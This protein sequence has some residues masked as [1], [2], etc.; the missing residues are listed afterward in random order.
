VCGKTLTTNESKVVGIGPECRKGLSKEFLDN[1]FA[2]KVGKV[3]YEHL[4]V[5]GGEG[6]TT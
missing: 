5:E 2:P 4:F 1:F 6:A 3:H